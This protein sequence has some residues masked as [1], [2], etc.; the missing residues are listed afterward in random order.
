MMET[1]PIEEYD[2]DETISPV[3]GAITAT[4]EA[5]GFLVAGYTESSSRRLDMALYEVREAIE[6]VKADSFPDNGFHVASVL[7]PDAG[8]T[9]NH[10]SDALSELTLLVD[11]CRLGL[12]SELRDGLI[13]VWQI[14]KR[15]QY[16]M[17]SG[18][19]W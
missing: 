7:S 16:T 10:L 12:P 6:S 19:E 11:A 14:L 8:V 13:V 1:A 3:V 15:A 2:H 9:Y 4:A 18:D 17:P 5:A